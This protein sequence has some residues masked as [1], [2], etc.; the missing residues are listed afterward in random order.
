MDDAQNVGYIIPIS[1]VSLFLN[2]Y[3]SSGRWLG[4]CELGFAYR[5]LE[6]EALREY[7]GVEGDAGILV[8]S[9]APLGSLRGILQ[10]NDV[11]LAVDGVEIH[12][13][14]TVIL[15]EEP[16][17]FQL[18]LD[19]L[20]TRKRPCQPL[21]L[22][23]MRAT[24]RIDLTAVAAP[25]PPLLPR[26][27]SQDAK[28]SFAIFGGLVFSRLSVPLYSEIQEDELAAP[29]AAALASEAQ[30]WKLFVGQETVVLLSILRHSINDGVDGTNALRFVT[31]VNDKPVDNLAAFVEE[32]LAIMSTLATC[33]PEKFVRFRF[34]TEMND[35]VSGVSEQEVLRAADLL[36]ADA[37]ILRQNNIAA[38]V[39]VDLADVYDRCAPPGNPISQGW[40]LCLRSLGKCG[41]A[42]KRVR[43][44]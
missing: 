22:S 13:D 33:A 40:V 27:L 35:G 1:V 20:F 26:Y 18:P 21:I 8:T 37:E 42:C 41:S 11:V 29:A 6:C 3:F 43:V 25:V 16:E 36:E 38:P 34:R 31:H 32:T 7:L 9:V 23:V 17:T 19:H 39:S 28:P 24:S 30:K 14:A 44:R 5:T 4:V 12:S 15:N 2:D 10:P